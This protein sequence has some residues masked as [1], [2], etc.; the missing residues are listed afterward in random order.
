M[1]KTITS[2]FFILISCFSFG[3]AEGILDAKSTQICDSMFTTA[4]GGNGLRGC[5]FDIVALNTIKITTFDIHLQDT[6]DIRIYYHLGTYVGTENIDTLWTFVGSIHNVDP[7]PFGT[8]T[9]LSANVARTIPAGQTGAFYITSTETNKNIYYTDGTSQGAIYRQDANMLLLEGCGIDYPFLGTPH[10]PRVFNGRIHYCYAPVGIDEQTMA[11]VKTTVSPNPFDNTAILTIEGETP[12]N[13]S[14][15][16][17]DVVGKLVNE[18]NNINSNE[19]TIN[20]GILTPGLYIYRVFS[21]TNALGN[22]KFIIE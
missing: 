5:M 4:A 12:A 9:R 2:C 15:K 1:K 10:T 13:Y 3:Q 11:A 18:I 17:F 8:L 16:I 7:R 14:V 22:G 20:K 6:T 21:K 19:I